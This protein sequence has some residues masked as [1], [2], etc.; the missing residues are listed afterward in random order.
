MKDCWIWLG[1]KDKDGYGPL[2][3]R[4]RYLKNLPTN[5][6]AHRFVWEFLFG[7]IPKGICFCHSCDNPSCVNPSHLW[8]AT[9]KKILAIEILKDI[10]FLV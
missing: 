2:Y 9:T 5:I 8:L 4:E 3:S 7:K 6:R 10:K 1:G